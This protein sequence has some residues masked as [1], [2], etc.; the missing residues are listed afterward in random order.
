VFWLVICYYSA[1]AREFRVDAKVVPM[2][3]RLFWVVARVFWLLG[4]WFT[5]SWDVG[6]VICHYY[7]VARGV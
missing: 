4:H 1:V 7:A 6:L 5:V 2:G 3:S